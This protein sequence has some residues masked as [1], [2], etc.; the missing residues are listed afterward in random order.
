[1]LLLRLV[2]LIHA[3]I[4]RDTLTPGARLPVVQRIS[5]LKVTRGVFFFTSDPV[6]AR[7][8]FGDAGKRQA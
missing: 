3:R 2:T 8:R 5:G 6:V 4:T 7:V 1:M